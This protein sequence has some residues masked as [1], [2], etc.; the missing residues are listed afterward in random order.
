MERARRS[1]DQNERTRLYAELQGLFAEEVPSLP[2]YYP[3]YDFAVSS[4]IKGVKP[5]VMAEPADRFRNV[6]EWYARTRREVVARR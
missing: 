2:L 3:T 4:K 5:G 1:V 6:V